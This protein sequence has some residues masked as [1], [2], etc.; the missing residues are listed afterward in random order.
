MLVPAQVPE[1]PEHRDD[2]L[3]ETLG[4]PFVPADRGSCREPAASR[5]GSTM[6]GSRGS[7]LKVITVA[8]T[9]TSRRTH[10]GISD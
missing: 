10:A 4:N 1:I 7:A 3:L 2:L 6:F 5:H 8:E 9:S